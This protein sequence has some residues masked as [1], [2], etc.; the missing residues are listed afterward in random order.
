[1][2]TNVDGRSKDSLVAWIKSEVETS[3]GAAPSASDNDFYAA[4]SGALL[5]L[6]REIN[7]RKG[8]FAPENQPSAFAEQLDLFMINYMKALVENNAGVQQAL[9]GFMTVYDNAESDEIT[10]EDR[11]FI[12]DEYEGAEEEEDEDGD[13]EDPGSGGEDAEEDEQEEDDE[14]GDAEGDDGEA[15]EEGDNDDDEEA[16]EQSDDGG[17]DS[18]GAQAENDSG[19]EEGADNE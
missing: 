3:G 18:D 6:L 7:T 14:E 13:Y 9:A 17:A 11:K 10:A 12:M 16:A 19:D 5:R 8:Q 1:M 2:I 15:A 4:V